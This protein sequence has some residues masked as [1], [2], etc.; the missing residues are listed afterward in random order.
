MDR[1]ELLRRYAA[2]ERD[3]SGVSLRGLDFSDC[4]LR[5]IILSNADLSM[6][7]WVGANL[8]RADLSG[9]IFHDGGLN[10][11]ILIEANLSRARLQDCALVGADLTD[12]CVQGTQFGNEPF[13]KRANLTGVNLSQASIDLPGGINNPRIAGAILCDT[14]LPDGG[15][16]TI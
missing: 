1:E 10:N 4:D 11:A 3:F 15:N 7:G 16:W 14:T 12:A 2:G 6:T 9:A 13:L 8:S 5:G